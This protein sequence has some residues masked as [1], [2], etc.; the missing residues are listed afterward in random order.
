MNE[1]QGFLR[2]WVT[3]AGGTLPV[4]GVA[5]RIQNEDGD[6][7]YVLRTGESGLTPTVALS[8]P[9]VEDSLQPGT[10]AYASY[11]VSVATEANAAPVPPL[12]VPIF[13]GITSLQPITLTPRTNATEPNA[14]APYLLFPKT[15]DAA[16]SNAPVP[17][18]PR[19][20]DDI[21]LPAYGQA[22]PQD[23]SGRAHT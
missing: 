10:K 2:I 5:V 4:P 16:V 23:G 1:S 15:D 22:L 20:M 6:L 14:K 8:A 18:E 13:A 7:L 12:S 17:P 21:D 3:A 19:A 11:Q 9:P